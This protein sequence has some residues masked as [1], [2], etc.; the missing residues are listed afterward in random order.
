MDQVSQSRFDEKRMDRITEYRWPL[1]MGEEA[2]DLQAVYLKRLRRLIGLREHHEEELNDDGLWLLDRSIFATYRD[3]IQIG[4]GFAAN[5]ILSG[6]P[7]GSRIS[8]G[9]PGSNT[10]LTY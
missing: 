8:D 9:K 2:S 4:A 5:D 10:P 6:S 3:C 1:E 7:L